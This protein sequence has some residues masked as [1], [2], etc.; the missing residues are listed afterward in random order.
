MDDTVVTENTSENL[1]FHWSL[2]GGAVVG[3]VPED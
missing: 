1:R 2:G 3:G